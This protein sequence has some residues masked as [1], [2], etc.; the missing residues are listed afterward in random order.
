[1]FLEAIGAFR[2]STKLLGVE[3]PYSRVDRVRERES[4]Q[5]FVESVGR[6]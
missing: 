3:F 5:Q 1:M 6:R 4:D 2:W